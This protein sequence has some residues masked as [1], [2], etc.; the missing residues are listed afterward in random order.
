MATFGERLR[1]LRKG[2]NMTQAALAE[3]VGVTKYTVSI[4]E[5]G[6]RK[7]EFNTLESLCNIFNCSLGYLLGTS[8]DDTPPM[9]MGMED[10]AVWMEADDLEAMQQTARLLTRLSS[11]SKMIISASIAQAYRLDKQAGN[12]QLGYDVKMSRFEKTPEGI[13]GEDA[14]SEKDTGGD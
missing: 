3:I 11:T 6:H 2:E 10:Q 5:Q 12:L 8:D 14:G 13:E 9:T 4:W 1:S 7:P